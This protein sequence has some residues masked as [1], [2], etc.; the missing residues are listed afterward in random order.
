M[1]KVLSII[2]TVLLVVSIIPT[3]LFSITASA[4]EYTEY[5]YTYT[6]SNNKATIVDVNTS[7]SGKIVI[8]TTLGNYTVTSIGGEAFRNCGKLTGI[9]IPDSV[10]SI[11]ANAFSACSNITSITISNAVTKIGDYAFSNCFSLKN[12]I[13]PD[14]VMNIGVGAFMF[15]NNLMN[16]TIGKNV[17]SIGSNA[18]SSCDNLEG[19]YI[20]DLAKW[21][22]ISFGNASSNPLNKARRLYLNDNVVS[23]L[24]IPDNITRIASFAFYNCDTL[25]SV[26]LGENVTQ[27]GS[28]AFYFCD[29]LTSVTISN[30]V[31]SI[32]SYAFS[33][34]NLTSVIIPNSITNISSYAFASCHNLRSITIPKSVKNIENNAF[35][36]CDNLAYVYYAGES[37]TGIN[38]YSSN[39][40]LYNAAWY[41]NACIG[42]VI[43][44]YDDNCDTEC[45]V[46]VELRAAPHCFDNACDTEC[47]VCDYIRTAPHDY[48]W[49]IDK[50][51]TCGVN[52]EKHEQCIGCH[53][54]R[55]GNTVIGAT[56]NHNFDNA[57]NTECN[58]CDYTRIAPHEYGWIIDKQE[59]CAANGVKHEECMVCHIRRNE[60][61]AIEATE[62]H[63]YDNNCDTECNVC[64]QIRTI[65]HDYKWVIDSAEN[66]GEDGIQ[67]EEC[68]VC[69]TRRNENTTIEA[70]ENHT[71]D[72]NCDTE[73]NVCKQI[74]TITH[75]YTV[76]CNHTCSVCKQSVKPDKPQIS[77]IK[78]DSVVLVSFD[79]FEYSLDGEN[80]QTSNVFTCL[81]PNTEYTFYQRV[82]AAVNALVSESSE[83]VA[84][85]TA[86]GFYITFDANGGMGTPEAQVKT[87][88]LDI[89]LSSETPTREGYV[90][91]G[92]SNHILGE[93]LYSAGDDYKIDKDIT[94]VALWLKSCESCSGSGIQPIATCFNCDGKGHTLNSIACISCG[95]TGVYFVKDDKE[96]ICFNC[97]K[98]DRYPNFAYL[99]QHIC[100]I[101]DGDGET[102]IC[103]AC[104]GVALYKCENTISIPAPQLVSVVCDIVT[105]RKLDYVEYSMDGEFWQTSNV[106]TGLTPNI[107]HTFYQ[108]LKETNFLLNGETSEPL[109]VYIE[110]HIYTNVCDTNC[111]ICDKQR[112][113]PHIYDNSTDLFCNLCNSVNSI[114]KYTIKDNAVTITELATTAAG[115]LIIPSEI[116]GYP[117]TSIDSFAFYECAG[118]TSV[119]IPDSV[120]SIGR[121]AFYGCTSL[122]SI[123]IP[124]VG[125]EYNGTSNTN[126]G[127]IFGAL[128]YAENKQYVPTSLKTVFINGGNLID[129]NAF[130]ECT[131]L[132]NIYITGDVRN[133]GFYA[134]AWCTN[135][136]KIY[137]PADV[138]SIKSYAL[139]KCSI[140]TV[141]GIADT[142]AE[143][144]AYIYSI[145]FQVAYGFE[146]GD[147]IVTPPYTPG[148]ID[149]AEGVTDRDAVHL[150]YHTFLP[151]LYP[152][153]QD[154]DFNGDN[155]VN[156]K[157]AIYLLYHTFLPD[158]YP[159]S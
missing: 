91:K 107:E 20:S 135:L 44:V 41:Y 75:D 46:C 60:N 85:S 139:D 136:E 108:R 62:N 123:S 119:I 65:T 113:A 55:N 146:D 37:Q 147:I 63:T 153:N 58:V 67:H 22:K 116:N 30:S 15:C 45:N 138:L 109:K 32:G 24:V 10:I 143:E 127:Y 124:F 40:E 21:C 52:G 31:T 111:N 125:K 151:N 5:Y 110:Q 96:F 142:E 50:Q 95:Q 144:F 87:E 82:K 72:N 106:F 34:T 145:P 57:C 158:L 118:L 115:E 70:T 66:C 100:I 2:L 11:G 92:W 51:E 29:N 89:V 8:P 1:K 99:K 19:V 126:F 56:G 159:I 122:A 68:T 155:E 101:C 48:E 148:N 104:E 97:L 114:L 157:D 150:L 43:H 33:N 94:L 47:N 39:L 152:V 18:F 121:G 71:Y 23:D 14:S 83:G 86:K 27:V 112:T 74:R 84:Q 130:Y 35:G 69:H 140:V 98:Y 64:K 36:W 78:A 81:A 76:N 149:S 117:V 90:F 120:T 128:T 59:T 6:V 73:C 13:I 53:V 25:N 38:I 132:K 93:I 105:L 77:K 79:G 12:L 16:I 17:T 7:I 9:T 102:G 156:D 88:G 28:S 103:S 131:S 3:G 154:C 133:I 134:F 129:D 80:W 141:Y 54:I 4:E 26:T 61:T 49:I 137:I 42:T